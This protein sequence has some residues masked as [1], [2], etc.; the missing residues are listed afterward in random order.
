[1]IAEVIVKAPEPTPKI[2]IIPKALED[3]PSDGIVRAMIA[4][5][6][7][8]Q[9]GRDAARRRP[10]SSPPISDGPPIKETSGE[11]GKR[12]E[13]D[14]PVRISEPSILVADLAAAHAVAAAALGK[15]ASVPAP[16]DSASPS[17]ELAVA[18]VRKDAIAASEA[19]EAFFTRAE[20]TAPFRP[21]SNSDSFDDLDEGYEP[22]K[23][24]DRVFGRR[25]KK[26]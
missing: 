2:T 16:G 11:I 9:V 15:A 18:E 25:P 21:P 26:P 23:F 10:P 24:W 19:E 5:A 20:H 14:T 8:D 4:T 7:T 22:P 12:P 6:D 3:D 1:M 13:A 17:R